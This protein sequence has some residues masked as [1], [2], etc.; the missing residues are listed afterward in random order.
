MSACSGSRH[1]AEE[2]AR[3]PTAL[4]ISA[5]GTEINSVCE[6]LT[7]PGDYTEQ[8]TK[9][10]FETG[11]FVSP[12]GT[13]DIFAAEAGRGN[14]RASVIAAVGIVTLRPDIVIFLGVAGGCKDVVKGDVVAAEKVYHYECGADAVTFKP[15]PD[16]G[17]PS[18]RMIQLA[19]AVS[20]RNAWQHRIILAPDKSP[21][22]YIGALA[23]GE[24]IVKKKRSATYK[25]IKASFSD[26]LAAETEG[27]GVLEAVHVCRD[28]D[29]IVI[30]G[31][32]DTINDKN[33]EQDAEW[34]PIAARNAA[35][36]AF[37]MLA[38]LAVSDVDLLRKA[39]MA[40]MAERQENDARLLRETEREL[41]TTI[42]RTEDVELD[43]HLQIMQK[44]YSIVRA[45]EKSRGRQLTS[46]E[47]FPG[48]LGCS[49]LT[50]TFWQFANFCARTAGF[51]HL[52]LYT[53][54][55]DDE[56]LLYAGAL[57]GIL[58][59]PQKNVVHIFYGRDRSKDVA[60]GRLLH[61]L[62]HEVGHM[63]LHGSQWLEQ[64]PGIGWR[65]KP[66]QEAE[67]CM[68]SDCLAALLSSRDNRAGRESYWIQHGK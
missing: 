42:V 52:L 56:R 7:D 27:A 2:P 24:K 46:E 55:K 45:F 3:N 36:F 34:Q 66:E 5:V 35:A 38:R 14:L 30:R 10:F 50:F 41:A 62:F 48:H 16:T 17:Q 47:F 19:R 65:P 58:I 44:V 23:S 25:L 53:L 18:H 15:R 67:A 39:R 33:E 29:A 9:T 64:K 61:S 43:N 4:F 12:H 1:V 13:W 40:L 63:V 28:I 51:D 37:E 11:T 31:I 54:T 32:S 60:S 68:F 59:N 57:S 6:H 49:T 26:A 22:G 8:I 21:S 20:R